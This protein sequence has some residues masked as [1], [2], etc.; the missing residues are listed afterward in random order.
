MLAEPDDEIAIELSGPP[1]NRAPGRI[2]AE[3]YGLR[4]PAS[5]N[6]P[7]N[8]AGVR[9]RHGRCSMWPDTEDRRSCVR[10]V[11]DAGAVRTI[12]FERPSRMCR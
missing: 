6:Y 10:Q 11:T 3:F 1:D 12:R 8:F 9:E 7:G 2:L 4:M 5:L